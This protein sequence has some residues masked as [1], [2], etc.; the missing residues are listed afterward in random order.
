MRS[1][2]RNLLAAAAAVALLGAT[3]G[4]SAASGSEGGDVNITIWSRAASIGKDAESAL[5]K[6]FPKYNIKVSPLG[7]DIDDKL[8]SGMRAKTGLP[9]VAIIA[10]NLPDY[11]QVSNQFVDLKAN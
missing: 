11:F 3:A 8:R 4:C 7:Q 6:K 10:G 9:D 1:A 5:Q 2:F